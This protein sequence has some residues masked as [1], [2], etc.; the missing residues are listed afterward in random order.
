MTSGF[1]NTIVLFI[2]LLYCFAVGGTNN[3]VSARL[4]HSYSYALDAERVVKNNPDELSAHIPQQAFSE[5]FAKYG[6]PQFFKV[7]IY[8]VTHATP[9]TKHFVSQKYS[10]YVRKTQNA[11][12]LDVADII[13]PF[14]SFW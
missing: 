8:F 11:Y 1:R 13:Y 10:Q 4:V 3:G 6:E 12:F 2:A 5:S 14:H 7:P 9:I